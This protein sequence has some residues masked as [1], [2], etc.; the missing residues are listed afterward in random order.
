MFIL[1]NFMLYTTEKI[2]YFVNT[3]HP[4]IEFAMFLLRKGPS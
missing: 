3:K 4:F 2:V 1:E